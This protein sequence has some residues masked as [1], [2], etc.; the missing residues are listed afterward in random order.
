MGKHVLMVY[1]NPTEGKEDEFNQWYNDIH[2]GEVLQ[3]PG[4]VSAQRFK[5]A[6]V[7]PGVS[8][9]QYLAL[10]NLDTDDPEGV[11]KALGAALPT[12][13]MSDAI[14]GRTAKMVV[15]SPVS[16]EQHEV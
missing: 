14:N 10:Y 11:I 2:L 12:M 6:D 1:T 16:D 9:H 3:V 4:I 8:D 13:N 15:V 5:V 7:M